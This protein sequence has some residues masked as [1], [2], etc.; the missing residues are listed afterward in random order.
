MTNRR[1]AALPRR[2]RRVRTNRTNASV[3]LGLRLRA[4][5]QKH[6]I[7]QAEL[8]EVLG[9]SGRVVSNIERGL[10]GL[11]PEEILKIESKYQASLN[12]VELADASRD[13]A[14]FYDEREFLSL[15]QN[16]LNVGDSQGEVGTYD[17]WFL[18]PESL[19]MLESPHMISTWGE[20]LAYG[21]SY[22]TI[23]IL[24][25]SS[26]DDLQ[27]FI[28][29]ACS[30]QQKSAAM[31]PNGDAG[32]RGAI[33]VYPITF[34]DPSPEQ[35]SQTNDYYNGLREKWREDQTAQRVLTLHLLLRFND[36][37]LPLR[38]LL[39]RYYLA[40]AAVVIYR[41]QRPFSDRPLVAMELKDVGNF[42]LSEPARAYCVLGE[43]TTTRIMRLLDPVANYYAQCSDGG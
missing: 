42:S 18:G 16:F 26:T 40:S 5:R 22:H 41:P 12:D 19:P 36:A 21:I 17:L 27:R 23:W 11:T 14:R 29:R 37:P 31:R 39:S 10:R 8:G 32:L 9:V 34:D 3:P 30:V 35:F 7:L 24:D 20:N 15:Q 6:G 2:Q 25:L 38:Q 1:R 28:A 33:H 4:F 43:T 13:P